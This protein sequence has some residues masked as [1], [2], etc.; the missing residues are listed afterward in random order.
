MLKKKGFYLIIAGLGILALVSRFFID[1][2]FKIIQGC[3]L[4]IGSGM[5]GLGFANFWM[6]K[7]EEQNPEQMKQSEIEAKDE[8]NQ[9]ILD[10]A[11]A[12]VGM[13]LHWGVMGIAWI[14]F[15]FDAPLWMGF[16]ALGIFFLY[17]LLCI[18]YV[19]RLEKEY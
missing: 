8:R 3:C 13:I 6:K 14:L 16:T 19:N 9:M 1:D 15:V 11:R 17:D 2:S 5:L 10:K 4:G 12:R 7:Y 18:I